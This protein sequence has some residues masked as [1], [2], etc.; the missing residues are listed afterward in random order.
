ME[1]VQLFFD[2]LKI[3][4]F[5]IGGG[6]AI[7]PL[8]N[9]Q[10]VGIRH[11]LTLQEFTDI[12]TISQMTPGPI[13]VNTSTFVGMRIAGVVG[14]IIATIGCIIVGIIISISLFKIFSKYAKSLYIAEILKGLKSASL[15]LI[16]AAGVL[17]IVSAFFNTGSIAIS[18]INFIAV[19][20]FIVSLLLIRKY[21]IHPILLMVI[22]GGLGSILYSF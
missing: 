22:A 13:A 10:V 6:Y 19:G 11:W 5:S 4:M 1:L 2:F 21:K 15:G 9:E 17:I 18:N 8:I 14:A 7:I 20:I 3:G 12:L 16:I